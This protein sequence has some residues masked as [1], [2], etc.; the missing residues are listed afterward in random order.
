MKISKPICSVCPNDLSTDQSV[1]DT[2]ISRLHELIHARVKWRLCFIGVRSAAFT[3]G[4]LRF[5]Y[6]YGEARIKREIKHEL[7]LSWNETFH[8]LTLIHCWHLTHIN[9]NISCYN[10]KIQKLFL[11]E[12]IKL[13]VNIYFS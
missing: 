12:F 3:R 9:L 6:S 5:K 11:F 4:E 10:S 2:R 8:L 13:F 1:S 7:I